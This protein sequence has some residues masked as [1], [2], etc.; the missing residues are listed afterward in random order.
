MEKFGT[1]RVFKNTQTKEVKKFLINEPVA[2][3]KTASV[4]DWEE[5][6]EIPAD[7]EDITNEKKSI[8]E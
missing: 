4:N 5:L 2:F 6:S 8:T 1:Y 7:A 3:E